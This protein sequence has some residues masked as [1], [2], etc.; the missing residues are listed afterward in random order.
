[1]ALPI[2]IDSD[3][4]V[5]DAVAI[6]WAATNPDIDLLAVS[7]VWGNVSVRVATDAILRVL[8]AA[9]RPDVP[10]A[11]GVDVPIAA[12]A[13][14]TRPA[15]FIHGDDGLGNTVDATAPFDAAPVGESSLDLLRRLVH[16]RPGEI[17][18]VTI[19]PLSNVGRIVTDDATFAPSV[20]DLI[21]M[22]GA[23]K[24]LGN[25]APIGEANVVHDPAAAH[26]VVTAAWPSPPLLVGLDV[27]HHATLSEREFDLLA[28]HRNAAAAFLD[29]P[30]AF[31]RRYGSTFTAPE[32]PCH[33]LV[34]VMASVTPD[35]ITD[36]PV[37]PLAVDCGGGPAWGATVVDFRAPYF[38]ALDGSVQETA[39]EFSP[40]RIALHADVARFRRDVRAFFGG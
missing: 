33:D 19:G 11:I 39:A 5:D 23:A 34:A 2:V 37:L 21:V 8:H 15:T 32:T 7:V 12:P 3:G 29:G 35:L 24:R 1:M 16:E 10:V 13:P 14:G 22:G 9:G 27:T 28:E 17:T 20:K 31:Y 18:L 38:A 4:G 25:A 30:L 36:A 40:W 6:W 26:A